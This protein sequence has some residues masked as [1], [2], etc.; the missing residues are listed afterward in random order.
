MPVRSRGRS[1]ISSVCW[2]RCC[3]TAPRV[4][5]GGR[6]K[7]ALDRDKSGAAPGAMQAM[8]PFSLRGRIAFASSGDIEIGRATCRDSVGQ[9]VYISVVE[10]KLK[11]KKTR[12]RSTKTHEEH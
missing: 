1:L 6:T 11:T 8:M 12:R 3:R 2:V 5:S 10:V 4:R 7:S 9:Y